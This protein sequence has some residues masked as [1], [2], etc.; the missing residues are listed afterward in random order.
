MTNMALSPKKLLHS[1]W[2]ATTP[3]NREM[4]FIVVRVTQ[5]E[6]DPQIVTEVTLEAVLSKRH[7]TLPWRDLSDEARWKAGWL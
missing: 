2:T 3:Q 6:T 4:H 5:D 1:K 7:Q